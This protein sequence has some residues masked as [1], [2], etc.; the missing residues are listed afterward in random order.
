MVPDVEQAV[1]ALTAK[2]VRMEHYDMPD[3]KI[4]PKGIARIGESGVAIAWF[5][6]PAGNILAII[7]RP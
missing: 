6:D 3:F 4:D 2:G 1:D 7:N 5:K